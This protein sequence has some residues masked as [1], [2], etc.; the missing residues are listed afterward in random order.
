M[1]AIFLATIPLLP[2]P[3]RITFNL[4]FIILSSKSNV[5]QTSLSSKFFALE[6]IAAASS[7]KYLLK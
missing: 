5:S 4:F 7:I 3:E 1:A 6:D 2:T